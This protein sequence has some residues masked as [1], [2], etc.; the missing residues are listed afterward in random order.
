M[1]MMKLV[2]EYSDKLKNNPND[3][4]CLLFALQIPSICSR[5]EFPKT[6]ENTGRAEEGN[7]IARTEDLTMQICIKLGYANIILVLLIFIEIR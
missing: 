2:Q 6:D 7:C 3:I 5:I 1:D 4:S